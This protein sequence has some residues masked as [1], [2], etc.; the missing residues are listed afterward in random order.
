MAEI[1]ALDSVKTLLDSMHSLVNIQSLDWYINPHFGLLFD[2]RENLSSISDPIK[3]HLPVTLQ[4]V[5]KNPSQKPPH[6]NFFKGL[7]RPKKNVWG[8][9][10]VVMEMSATEGAG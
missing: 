10:V 5:L 7:P 4:S 2:D 3:L 8:V 1:K 9:Y 6:L